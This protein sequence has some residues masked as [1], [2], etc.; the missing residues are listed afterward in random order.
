M[1]DQEEAPGRNE[2]NKLVP[3][4]EPSSEIRGTATARLQTIANLLTVVVALSAILLSVWEG[5]ENRRHN[6]L[7]VLPHLEP[8]EADYGSATPIENE[9]FLLPSKM[10][11]LYAVS[12][13]LENSG[14]G[15]AVLENILIFEENEKIFD[16]AQ[17]DST[18]A[19]HEV[20]RDLGQLPFA[21]SLFQNPYSVGDM[22]QAGEVHYYMTV[23]IP[24]SVTRGALDQWPP[25]IVQ[26]EVLE[27]R[28][29]VFCY[30][31]VYEEDCDMTYLGSAPPVNNV[32]GF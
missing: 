10:D 26:S 2:D 6:R 21:A 22:L 16:S 12:Y 15:P 20:K 30:C 23:A 19:F 25:D 3:E 11:S 32:C 7:S 29:F 9:Y 1:P 31:S 27:Q 13:A 14:L 17:L 8:A 5:I 18:Y 24:F 4:Q 28:T